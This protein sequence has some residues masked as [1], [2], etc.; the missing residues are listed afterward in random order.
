MN[1]DTPHATARIP[2]V[3]TTG[4]VWLP[5]RLGAFVQIGQTTVL[6]KVRQHCLPALKLPFAM[7][8]SVTHL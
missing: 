5:A 3:D 2:E 6:I 8:P 7:S 1:L 4:K